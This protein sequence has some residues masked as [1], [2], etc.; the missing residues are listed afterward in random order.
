VL[1]HRL[2]ID[3]DRSLRGLS[4]EAVLDDVLGTVPVPPISADGA[5]G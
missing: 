4:A 2:Q 1:G 5:D 3:L